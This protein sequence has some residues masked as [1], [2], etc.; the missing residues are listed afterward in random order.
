M[1]G[2]VESKAKPGRRDGDLKAVRF[3]DDIFVLLTF[4]DENLK[5]SS[6]PWLRYR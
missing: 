4:L 1:V 2:R 3:V 5:L 6:L